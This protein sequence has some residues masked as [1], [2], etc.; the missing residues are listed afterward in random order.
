MR[1]FNYIWLLIV[2]FSCGKTNDPPYRICSQEITNIPSIGDTIPLVTC[3]NRFAGN[4]NDIHWVVYLD[5][6]KVYESFNSNTYYITK[7]I[8][9]HEINLE[10][11][12]YTNKKNQEYEVQQI[13]KYY[14]ENTNSKSIVSYKYNLNDDLEVKLFKNG[15]LLDTKIL[16]QPLQNFQNP[17]CNIQNQS[18]VIFNNVSQGTYT[19]EA[20]YVN[21]GSNPWYKIFTINESDLL[22]TK[23]EL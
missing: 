21:S 10:T 14:F 20:S 23:I 15:Q 4:K 5:N 17:V 6:I 22:C 11:I 3:N 8:G 7:G 1:F 19:I 18:W 2:L 13:D 12:R 16:T 9:Y